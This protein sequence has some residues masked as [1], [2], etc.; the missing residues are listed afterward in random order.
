MFWL[1]ERHCRVENNYQIVC[2]ILIRILKVIKFSK[3]YPV[4]H[5]ISIYFVSALK[6]KLVKVFFF[7]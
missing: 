5:G 2:F 7:F 3:S 4:A 6:D 1:W